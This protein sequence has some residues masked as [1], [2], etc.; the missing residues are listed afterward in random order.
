MSESIERSTKIERKPVYRPE[1]VHAPQPDPGQF[2]YTRGI[3]PTMYSGRLWTMR[4]YAGF[5][6]A[7]ETNERFRFLLSQGVMGLSTAFDLPTQ[8]GLDSDDPR[9]EGEVGKVGVAIDT[10]EDMAQLFDG[11]PLDQVSTSMTIN[12][13]AALL[14]L[15]YELVGERQGVPSKALTGT[16]Q[17]DILKEYAARGT[18]IFP[19]RPSMRLVTD[20]FAYCRDNIPKWN[21]ISISGYH[22]REAG[23]T[24]VQELAFTLANGIAY[25]QAALEAGLEVD[26]FAPRLSFFFNAH[27]NFFEEIAKFRAARRMWSTIMRDRFGAK[28]ERSMQLRFHTQTAGST[29]TSQQPLNNV[30]RT[31]LEALAA[32][33]GGTQSLHTNGYDEALSLPTAEAATLALRTQQIIAF[34]SGV[35]EVADP[36][37]GSYYI[38]SLTDGLEAEATRLITQI[39]EL[40][41][42]VRAIEEGVIQGQIAD[43]AWET[44]QAIE[45]KSQVVVGVNKFVS[46]QATQVPVFYPNATVAAEQSE[47]LARIRS[48]RDRA[49]VDA[50]LEDVRRAAQGSANLLVPMREALRSQATLGEVCG[51]LRQEWSEYRPEVAI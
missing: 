43:S 30:V 15:M 29:L 18:Y 14:L 2:P 33:L 4:Q 44:Q 13:P 36:F 32:V 20:T 46:D 38:E 23:S 5:S 12:A 19:P 51:V 28:D 25:V 8:L 48:T 1:D 41:G 27:S 21:T 42:A 49:A 22:I 50:A 47:S 26:V 7:R 10:V 35:P 34:E 3:Y 31:T 6:S 39:D 9:A 17:N 45:Q 11:I 40:G 37:G 24:A 16:I